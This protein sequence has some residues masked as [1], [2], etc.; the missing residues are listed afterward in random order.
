[1]EQ[2]KYVCFQIE[3]DERSDR[4]IAKRGRVNGICP[5][6]EGNEIGSGKFIGRNEE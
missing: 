1:M 4:W 2:L 6:D 3:L 5:V